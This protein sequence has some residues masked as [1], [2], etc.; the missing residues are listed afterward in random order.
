MPVLR[1]V[2]ACVGRNSVRPTKYE[3]IAIGRGLYGRE[4]G[5]RVLCVH[6]LGYTTKV[7]R[8]ALRWNVQ[9]GGLGSAHDD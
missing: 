6:H 1:L 8:F 3:H 7:V 2:S 9:G 5:V 4:P